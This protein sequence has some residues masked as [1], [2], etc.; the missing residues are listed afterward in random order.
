LIIVYHSRK[1]HQV[2][3]EL[4]KFIKQITDLREKVC[5]YA[6]SPELEV[7]IE[8]FYEVKDLIIGIPL[9]DS[10]YNAYRSVFSGKK[11]IKQ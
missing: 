7:L 1:Q 3:D 5:V 4:C 10:I 2:T 11:D 6:F 8:D 9:P